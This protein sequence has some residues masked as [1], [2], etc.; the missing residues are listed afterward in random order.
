MDEREMLN[1]VIPVRHASL[2]G[3]VKLPRRY[4]KAA[5]GTS[6]IPA[7]MRK[8]S[9]QPGHTP[10]RDSLSDRLTDLMTAILWIK[11]ELIMLRQHDILLKRQFFDIQDS[12]SSLRRP[13]P[14]DP[15]YP[16]TAAFVSPPG[17]ALCNGSCQ[18]DCS[19]ATRLQ[20]PDQMDFPLE[21][22]A[23]R[24]SSSVTMLNDHSD[25]E[26][27]DSDVFLENYFRPRTG[28]MKTS[29]DMAALARRR[30][31]KELI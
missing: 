26:A 10:L 6:G 31:S 2:P 4:E 23:V 1:G 15:S 12:I 20:L 18:P 19:A 9:I 22:Y 14:H 11:Q 8:I 21:T 29:R 27:E 30:G 28:S 17:P 7:R 5:M 13:R 3:H 16:V 24:T 25:D